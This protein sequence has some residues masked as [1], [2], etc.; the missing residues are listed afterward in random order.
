MAI[1]LQKYTERGKV[2]LKTGERVLSTTGAPHIYGLPLYI[3]YLQLYTCR[4]GVDLIYF[5]MTWGAPMLSTKASV[6][7]HSYSGHFDKMKNRHLFLYLLL[8][9]YVSVFLCQ[10]SIRVRLPSVITRGT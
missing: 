4:I 7:M 5:R 8:I 3:L 6:K 9:L 10:P 2:K 1:K